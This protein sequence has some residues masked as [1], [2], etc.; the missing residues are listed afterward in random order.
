MRPEQR[1]QAQSN[2][3]EMSGSIA[4]VVIILIG[5]IFIKISGSSGRVIDTKYMEIAEVKLVDSILA[6][7]GDCTKNSLVYDSHNYEINGN[8]LSLEISFSKAEDFSNGNSF[9]IV[10]EDESLTEVDLVV[11]QGKSADDLKHI[12][13]REETK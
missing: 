11:L 6:I 10:I 3:L 12:W 7:T 13:V 9:E 2:M 8:I 4:L 1:K 5:V